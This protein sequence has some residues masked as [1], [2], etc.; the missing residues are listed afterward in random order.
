MR[1]IKS[2]SHPCNTLVCPFSSS[3]GPVQVLLWSGAGIFELGVTPFKATRDLVG[4]Y[5]SPT[6]PVCVL[7]CVCDLTGTTCTQPG[8]CSSADQLLLLVFTW[9]KWEKAAELYSIT[10]S[11]L[12]LSVHYGSQKVPLLFLFVCL[13]FFLAVR[14]LVSGSLSV[15]L[16]LSRDCCLYRLRTTSIKLCGIRNTVHNN[17]FILFTLNSGSIFLCSDLH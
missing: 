11:S 7:C 3:L 6:A 14:R 4:H 1:T 9:S 2:N 13:G 5:R 8:T 16:S 12:F 17:V 15:F 10:W